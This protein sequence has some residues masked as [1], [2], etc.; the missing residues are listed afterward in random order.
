[1]KSAEEVKC[2]VLQ[3][4][5]GYLELTF[6]ADRMLFCNREGISRWTLWWFAIS[7]YFWRFWDNV[8]HQISSTGLWR[9]GIKRL[10]GA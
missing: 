4:P 8:Y 9:A 10:E 2:W 1:V 3:A 5:L 7:F 6:G